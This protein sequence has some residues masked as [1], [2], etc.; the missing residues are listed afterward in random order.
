MSA[1]PIGAL[2][3]R[4]T[5]EA[6]VRTSEEGGAAVIDWSEVAIISAEVVAQSGREI[7][8][9]D[10]LTGRLTHEIVIRYRAD[11]T[12]T[13]RFRDGERVFAIHAVLDVDGRRRWLKCLCEERLP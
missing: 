13:M 1:P 6:P 9:A 5:L 7:V 8:R 10:G 11:A 12:P 4:L 2:R 3:R